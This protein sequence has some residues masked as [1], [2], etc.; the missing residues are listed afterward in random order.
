VKYFCIAFVIF[1][2]VTDAWAR[3]TQVSGIASYGR[4]TGEHE[5]VRGQFAPMVGASLNLRLF[6]PEIRI[7]Y[8]YVPWDRRGHLYLVG[9]GWFIQ[10]QM[11]PIRPFFQVGW[12]GGVE[13]VAYRRNPKFQ[14]LGASAGFTRTVGSRL[15][16]R[17]EVRF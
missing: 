14:G 9:A 13:T 10:T 6:K 12:V 5:D 11:K 17:P 2:V 4:V 16:I 8:E 1:G 15:F 7:D 3:Q